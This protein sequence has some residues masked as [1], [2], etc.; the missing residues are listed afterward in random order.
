MNA[1]KRPLN[2]HEHYH[3]HV[4]FD[5]KSLQF[6][7]RL[8]EQ[9]ANLFNLK[10]GRIHQK[11]VGPHPQWSC[12]ISFSSSDFEQLI[13][14]L[15]DNRNEL[16]ILVHAQTGDDL[17]DHTEFAYWLGDEAQLNLSAFGG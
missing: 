3:A 5:S 17:K 10:M 13:A 15:D 9:A 8:C 6:A 16:T 12:Q 11:L 7:S 14:W 1:I 2:N 4:Y